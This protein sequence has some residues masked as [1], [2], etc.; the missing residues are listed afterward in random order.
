MYMSALQGS[1]S[2]AFSRGEIDGAIVDQEMILGE[3]E[4]CDGIPEIRFNA[5]NGITGAG[6]PDASF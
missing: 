5:E 6:D 4:P 3:P 1:Q 2:C